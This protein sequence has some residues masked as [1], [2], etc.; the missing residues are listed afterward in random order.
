MI[1]NVY[2][3]I[4]YKGDPNGCD[5]PQDYNYEECVALES[6]LTEKQVKQRLGAIAN[7][8]SDPT[9]IFVGQF[10][11]IGSVSALSICYDVVPESK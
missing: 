7:C 1:Y 2:H 8:N 3:I 9:Y 4:G 11:L 5:G 10:E 6:T